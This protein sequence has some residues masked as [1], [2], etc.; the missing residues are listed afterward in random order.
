M[1]ADQTL[2]G[3]TIEP[4][5]WQCTSRHDRRL[6]EL[7]QRCAGSVDI[8]RSHER[9]AH[10]FRVLLPAHAHRAESVSRMRR[11][12][13]KRRQMMIAQQ[14]GEMVAA[15]ATFRRISQHH[16]MRN[17]QRRRHWL[18]RTGVDFVVQRGSLR[19]SITISHD[20]IWKR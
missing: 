17:R 9:A 12:V 8:E 4:H 3:Q 10:K 6:R 16:H 14:G 5:L 20:E 2:T 15:R 1:R 7:R 18:L 13:V 11:F 19:Q